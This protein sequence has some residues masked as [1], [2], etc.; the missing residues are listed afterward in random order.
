[1]EHS[2]GKK[3]KPDNHK[4]Q[5]NGSFDFISDYHCTKKVSCLKQIFSAKLKNMELQK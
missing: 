4:K 2:G 3:E 5:T 1:M